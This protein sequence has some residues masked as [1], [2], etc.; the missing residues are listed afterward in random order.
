MIITIMIMIITIEKEVKFKATKKDLDYFWKRNCKNIKAVTFQK[1]R[2]IQKDFLVAT[3]NFIL[4]YLHHYLELLLS[5][6]CYIT[7]N[8]FIFI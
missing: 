3:F 5:L 1:W 7:Y 4:S 8:D 6:L 2:Y